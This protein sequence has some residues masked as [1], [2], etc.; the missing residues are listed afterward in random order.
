MLPALLLAATVGWSLPLDGPWK[1][2]PGD[3]PR[4]A[5]PA[6][7]DS[8]WATQ[9]LAAPVSSNDGDQG[10]THYAPGW[11]AQGFRGYRGFAWYRIRVDTPLLARG[12]LAI[13]GPAMADSAYQVYAGGKLAGGIGDFSGSKP[14]AYAIHPAMF[15]IAAR[16]PLLIAVRVWMGPWVAGPRSGGMRVAPVVGNAPGAGDA[17]A[18]QWFEKIRA[19]SL[20]IVQACLFVGLA[21]V[22]LLLLGLQP[23]KRG[24][25][26]LAI[27]LLLT[28]AERAHLTIFWCLGIESVPAFFTVS[29]LL[30]PATLGSWVLAWAYWLDL[31]KPRLA[32]A[33]I[34]VTVVYALT[35]LLRLPALNGDGFPNLA[36][37]S[38]TLSTF[39]RCGLLAL[40]A[41]VAYFGI[42]ERRRETFAALPS[43]LLVAIGQFGI[44]LVRLGVPGIWF[45]F[46][47][48]VSLANYAY[49]VS[50]VAIFAL[51]FRSASRSAPARAAAPM[52]S[53]SKLPA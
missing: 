29:V 23:N 14:V 51:L 21:V 15:A 10:I 40:L 38:A 32:G 3:D 5:S 22:S 20:E 53:F 28:A 27:A 37:T 12:D 4:W 2:H 50:N 1:F 9:S 47:M 34:A 42:V 26:V 17:Y 19:F 18:V 44:E 25:A 43:I 36:V 13:L 45:P 6:F 8:A 52:P 41:L 46:G 24:P 33:T 16:G 39:E 30:V 11:A 7:D 35:G 49:L 48:G 31:R